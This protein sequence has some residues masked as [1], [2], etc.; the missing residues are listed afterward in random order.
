[1]E[2]GVLGARLR[3]QQQIDDPLI[4]AAEPLELEARS[5]LWPHARQWALIELTGLLEDGARRLEEYRL[6]PATSAVDLPAFGGPGLPL[7]ILF[8]RTPNGASR[9]RLYSVPALAGTRSSALAIDAHLQP[10]R[11]ARDALARHLA[12][13]QAGDLAATLESFEPQGCLQDFDGALHCGR[14]QLREVYV[15]RYARGG[16]RLSYCSRL[17]DGPR[18]ALELQDATG[19]PALAV[20]ERGRADALTAVRLYA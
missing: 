9:A 12:A 11:D 13:L 10:P 8:E 17:Q 16:L 5:L 18:T 14:E 6:T 20:C 4:G 19:R 7:A 15:R 3:Q 2:P 1:V